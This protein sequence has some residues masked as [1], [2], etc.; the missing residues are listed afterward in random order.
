MSHGSILTLLSLQHART[1]TTEDKKYAQQRIKELQPK[2]SRPAKQPWR[3]STN[4]TYDLGELKRLNAAALSNSQI[5]RMHILPR[6]YDERVHPIHKFGFK[7]SG[8]TAKEFPEPPD[9]LQT[10]DGKARLDRC[11][12]TFAKYVDG[13]K[14]AEEFF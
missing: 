4:H 3:E 13:K 5:A 7:Q 8:K 10:I 14:N 12:E 1:K 2:A 6:S 9:N 11:R